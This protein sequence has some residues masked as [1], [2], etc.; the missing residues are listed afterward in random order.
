[1]GRPPGVRNKGEPNDGVLYLRC[2]EGLREWLEEQA[3]RFGA[4][5]TNAFAVYLLRTQ[6]RRECSHGPWEKELGQQRCGK[7]GIVV[8]LKG[9]K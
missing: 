7:C 3:M 2:P 9:K 6:Q 4:R 5:T 1:M 8:P